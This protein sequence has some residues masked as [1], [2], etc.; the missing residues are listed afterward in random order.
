MLRTPR[1]LVVALVSLSFVGSAPSLAEAQQGRVVVADVGMGFGLGQELASNCDFVDAKLAGCAPLNLGLTAEFALHVH[2]HI[3]LL[4][5]GRWSRATANTTGVVPG[6]RA[7]ST[8]FDAQGV[9]AALG[10]RFY[11]RPFYSSVRPFATVT[12]GW[13]EV[14]GETTVLGMT[15]KGSSTAFG[16]G[17]SPGVDIQLSDRLTYRVAGIVTLGFPEKR[18]QGATANMGIRTG[19]VLRLN[20]SPTPPLPAHVQK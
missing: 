1:V 7:T 17:V 10:A 15:A 19:I 3:A 8:P 18:A 5:G 4:I 16:F 11:A 20:S 6:R 14:S 9:S 2:D 13:Q 12:V